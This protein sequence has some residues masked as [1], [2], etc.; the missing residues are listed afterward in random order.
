[1]KGRPVRISY[2][3]T[4][5]VHADIRMKGATA[6][7]EAMRCRARIPADTINQPPP[8]IVV[9]FVVVVVVVVFELVHGIRES[10]QPR[11]WINQDIRASF[12]CDRGR[13]KD[14]EPRS[15]P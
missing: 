4:L 3:E 13:C 11:T 12:A 7:L 2:A 5:L 8:V 14:G 9:V 6:V 15:T 10:R 1:M